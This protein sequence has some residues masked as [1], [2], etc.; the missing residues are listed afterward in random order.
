M[1]RYGGSGG[2]GLFYLNWRKR[3]L[4]LI[5]DEIYLVGDPIFEDLDG[6]GFVEIFLPGNS[7]GWRSTWGA[8]VL[9]WE[10]NSYKIWWPDWTSQK[11]MES[12][13]RPSPINIPYVMYARLVDLEDDGQ[14]EI[15]AVLD[16]GGES[17]L[18]EL[19]VWK[20]AKGTFTLADK[21]ALPDWD[22]IWSE[23][24]N[25]VTTSNGAEI[26]LSD[27]D[28]KGILRCV[29]FKGKIT[30]AETINR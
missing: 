19:G 12:R 20:L 3:S 4:E 5:T 24:V 30:C 18:R 7:T 11:I 26:Y 29:F 10:S 13:P 6:D 9:R 1:T 8:A 28:K 27:P 17:Q 22:M 15:V 16:A 21:V 2:Y 23:I 14:K 25:I